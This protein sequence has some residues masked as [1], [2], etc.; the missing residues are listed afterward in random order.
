MRSEFCDAVARWVPWPGPY[1]RQP[2]ACHHRPGAADVSEQALARG[3][4]RR[5]TET[6]YDTNNLL[7]TLFENIV[8]VM[9]FLEAEVSYLRGQPAGRL[10]TTSPEGV[11]QIN[12]VPF[13]V[14]AQRGLIH[15]GGYD[16]GR[17]KKFHNVERGSINVAFIADELPSNEH[18]QDR[19]IEV[20]GWAEALRDQPPCL[21]GLSGELLRIHP[22]LIFSWSVEPA[23]DGRQRRVVDTG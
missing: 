23:V 6:V 15:I 9:I 22:R 5:L 7:R 18:Q 21:E 13:E 2:F 3:E 20:H 19:G 4:G 1:L 12:S 8:L 14:D 11:V 10:A 17:S 16:M